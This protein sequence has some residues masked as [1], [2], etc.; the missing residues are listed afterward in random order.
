MAATVSL[1]FTNEALVGMITEGSLM[2][3]IP[4]IL[5][6][7]WKIKSKEKVMEP[8]M[9]GA[10]AWFV[11]AIL[12][13]IAPAYFLYQADNPVAKAIGGNVWL[14]C[15]VAGILAGVFE[16]TGR[17]LAFRF[18][19]KKWKGR[20]TAISYG[21]GHGGFESMYIGFQMLSL[22]VLGVMM[23]RGMA[24]QIM[25]GTDEATKAM[26]VTQLEPYTKVT[27]AECLLAVFERL[28]AITIHLSL[29]VPVFAAVREKRY[30]YLYPLA[31]V[32]H[33]AFDFSTV[34]Y[35]AG[36]LPVW[37][38]EL[39]LAV[40][41]AAMAVFAAKIYRKL[42]ESEEIKQKENVTS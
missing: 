30:R 10:A 24:D 3:V 36:F 19:L 4:I 2:M 7:V 29:S 18:L 40:I 9:V 38:V 20:R 32:L 1:H 11:F 41:A 8:V 26:L 34:V 23:S 16:E 42:D 21:I 13:K 25:S 5:L 17:F 14:S 6:I 28:P 22:V 27:L 37:G 31:I 35:Q 33:A 39:M 15:L 12:L